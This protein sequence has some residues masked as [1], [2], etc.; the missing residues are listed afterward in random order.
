MFWEEEFYDMFLRRWNQHD[1]RHVGDTMETLKLF[2]DCIEV[3]NM[4]GD[5]FCNDNAKILLALRHVRRLIVRNLVPQAPSWDI[6][7]RLVKENCHLSELVFSEVKFSN[8]EFG[9]LC[10]MITTTVE[11]A[12]D[13]CRITTLDFVKVVIEPEG[14]RRLVALVGEM[15]QLIQLSLTSSS[16]KFYNKLLVDAALRVPTLERLFLINY[17]GDGAFN[18]LA[19]LRK[20]LPLRYLGS[21][22][23][24]V[25][26]KTLRAICR[27][28]MNVVLNLERLDLDSNTRIN[29][30][31]IY[32][33]A[34]MLASPVVGLATRLTHL[35]LSSCKFGL[36]GVTYLLLAL[37][38]NNTVKHLNL[39]DNRFGVGFGDVLA[40]FLLVKSSIK[41]LN[42][43]KVELELSGV[44]DALLTALESNL[45]LTSLSLGANGLQD[46]GATTILKAL[47]K[48]AHLKPFKSIDLSSNGITVGGLKLIADIFDSI[49]SANVTHAHAAGR[50]GV[51]VSCTKRQRVEDSDNIHRPSSAD[52]VLFKKLR[53][54]YNNFNVIGEAGRECEL[55]L[56]S[57]RRYVGHVKLNA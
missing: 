29:D 41:D 22:N 32:T 43:F 18:G 42:I 5:E 53:L 44:S 25:S 45:T 24:N 21:G 36:V 57:I 40:N 3:L 8:S 31:A 30:P 27:A 15:P 39:A 37:G 20:P 12:L 10:T 6:M 52:I 11:K 38:Q 17:F 34:P 47:V 51:D 14:Y 50:Y 1:L 33:L 2:T 26:F 35:D 28:S 23:I 46:R 7:T 19:E 54:V 16:T 13:I 9:S 55:L 48:R 56:E 4:S 49:M